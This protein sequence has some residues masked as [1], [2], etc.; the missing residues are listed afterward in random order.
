MPSLNTSSSSDPSKS[1]QEP[2]PTINPYAATFSDEWMTATG[3]RLAELNAQR[4][5]PASAESTVTPMAPMDSAT[6]TT[7]SDM[8]TLTT[9]IVPDFK[10]TYEHT[11][12]AGAQGTTV[13]PSPATDNSFAS[14]RLTSG[15]T[16]G[17]VS[18]IATVDAASTTDASYEDA[19]T[20]VSV[21]VQTSNTTPSP[22]STVQA[23]GPETAMES[24]VISTAFITVP[25]S[26]DTVSTTTTSP[27]TTTLT[28]KT[29][30][31]LPGEGSVEPSDTSVNVPMPSAGSITT[32][33]SAALASF[34]SPAYSPALDPERTE[35]IAHSPQSDTL[36]STAAASSPAH[37]SA[38]ST[39]D[40]T[41]TPTG[42]VVNPISLGSG[43]IYSGPVDSITATE[44]EDPRRNPYFARWVTVETPVPPTSSPPISTSHPF[45]STNSQAR[46]HHHHRHLHLNSPLPIWL[47]ASIFIAGG[48]F[49]VWRSL[50]YTLARR[51]ARAARERSFD[52]R[53]CDVDGT[54]DWRGRGKPRR[55]GLRKRCST[56]DTC[57][58]GGGSGRVLT[59]SSPA[60]ESGYVSGQQASEADP[61]Y[62]PH[63]RGRWEFERRG[64]MA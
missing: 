16:V 40:P 30:S 35:G 32:S 43:P 28:L 49:L 51:R 56:G 19:A 27:I 53:N 64:S 2:L 60:S 6:I 38:T 3:S 9:A 10:S 22:D 26:L 41:T 34:S 24:P 25:A 33:M 12:T 42:L 48:V 63:E 52:L 61:M 5:Q 62:R 46:Y 45:R 55:P 44:H 29:T 54:C 4:M 11:A 23:T 31:T 7:G 8:M 17:T 59:P 36:T 58:Y 39:A 47:A 1:P 21:T 57:G 18:D 50:A 20:T 14:V 15:E 13:L 37:A